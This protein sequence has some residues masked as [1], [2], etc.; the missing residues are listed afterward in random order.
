MTVSNPNHDE[1]FYAD[2][3]QQRLR[4]VGR[5]SAG[6]LVLE[7]LDK[8][9]SP[10]P[11]I[12]VTDKYA[13]EHLVTWTEKSV[14]LGRGQMWHR[15]SHDYADRSARI[16]AI[17]EYSGDNFVIY[18]EFYSHSKNPKMKKEIDFRRVYGRLLVSENGTDNTPDWA[19][20]PLVAPHQYAGKGR[21]HGICRCGEGSDAEIHQTGEA[22]TD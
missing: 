2:D 9:D 19:L 10:D 22:E 17:V 5:T 13:S 12:T 11:L 1:I 14:V 18:E 21:L 7:P 3:L 4:F 20:G 16:L 6:L 8:P 15:S